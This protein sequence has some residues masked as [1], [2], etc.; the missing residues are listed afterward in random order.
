MIAVMEF[1]DVVR[2]RRMVR[3]YSPDP[4]DPA[5]VDRMPSN[6]VHAPSAGFRQGWGFLVLDRPADVDRLWAATT[7]SDLESLLAGCAGCGR[8][9]W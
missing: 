7:P 3:R 2:R 5:V 8:R 9:P 4:V 1:T 6:A